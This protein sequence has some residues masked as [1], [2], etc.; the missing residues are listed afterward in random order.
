MS[1]FFSIPSP[2]IA[3]NTAPPIAPPGPKAAPIAPPA[4]APPIAPPPVASP[5]SSESLNSISLPP[6]VWGDLGVISSTS[7]PTMLSCR[8]TLH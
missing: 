6:S 1:S 8:E 3:P 7:S 2:R 5:P 4:I